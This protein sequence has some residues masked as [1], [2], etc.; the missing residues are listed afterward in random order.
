[1]KAIFNWIINTFSYIQ[2][3][4][5]LCLLFLLSLL[6]I[7][8]FWVQTHRD[9][10]HLLDKQLE[11]LKE[12][13]ALKD[14]YNIVQ[15]HRLLM[16]R[17]L[18]D[19]NPM[20]LAEINPY[21]ER[22][23][24]LLQ[25]SDSPFLNNKPTQDLLHWLNLRS[26]DISQELDSIFNQKDT[27]TPREIET[28][29]TELLNEIGLQVDYLGD[30]VNLNYFD[31]APEY[32]Y[33]QNILLRLPE[34][35]KELAEL[36]LISEKKL[37]SRSYELAR[38]R[39][40][41]LI[42]LIEFELDY[43]RTGIESDR[44]QN[45]NLQNLEINHLLEKYLKMAQ[46]LVNTVKTEIVDV[47][48]PAITLEAF[49]NVSRG[50][51][52]IGYQIWEDSLKELTNIFEKERQIV[53]YRLWSIVLATIII[54]GIT[55]YIGL[56]LTTNGIKRLTELTHL[57]NRFSNGELS[58]RAH[59][60]NQ[61]DI[62]RQ[63]HAFNRM[64]KKL[65]ELITRLFD[66]RESTKALA[67]GNLS[68]RIERN[69]QDTEF[70][71]VAI[72][73]NKMAETFDNIIRRLQQIGQMLS[74]SAAKIASGSKDQEAII[75]EQEAT[76]REISVTANH[77]SSTAKELAKTMNDVSQSADETSQLA[78]KGKES[79]NDMEAI[80]H[81]MVDASGK[82]AGKLGILNEKASKITY[83][84][85]TIT[86][87]A[88]QTNLLSLNASIEAEKAG[89]FGKSFA[90]I[91]REMRRLADQTA[92]STLDIEK[93]INEIMAAVS[94]SVMGMDD[95]TH[96]IRKGVDQVKSVSEHLAA[97][98]EHF[99]AFTHRFEK[100]NQGMQ[101]QST[102]AEQINHAIRQLSDTAQQTSAAVHEFLKTVNE[103][104]QAASELEIFKS[105]FR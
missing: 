79:L 98:I 87:V 5:S 14:A 40:L 80:M 57:T 43:F 105:F 16:Q 25:N 13:S 61:D 4:I 30:R 60:P 76:T 38:D 19:H 28:L 93:M 12:E 22:L 65:E 24:K 81:N 62:G 1:M 97:I 34:F 39:L 91:A 88:D 86:K 48:Q 33:I 41:A 26:I 20:Y 2:I 52:Q 90:V 31:E 73:F 63:A 32:V 89:E 69:N 9:L 17:Y 35:Q 85:T 15:Q 18:K 53:L 68:T 36:R 55:F 47:E 42:V 96:A 74:S 94:S 29:Y 82:I 75:M 50:N 64:A 100:V 72:S 45:K 27:L 103:L 84:I 99:H 83:V 10:L 46:T 70:D 21:Q 49:Q 7:V 102:G 23:H 71:P 37:S 66:L 8:F 104:N 77:I 67:A 78:I 101:A 3:Y 11:E 58:V 51:L 54:S 44:R 95:F 6:P 56:S 59:D 92:V